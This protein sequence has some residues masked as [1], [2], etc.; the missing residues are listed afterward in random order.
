MVAQ[1]TSK[2]Y[3]SFFQNIFFVRTIFY[4]PLK[5]LLDYDPKRRPSSQS[6]S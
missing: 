2:K 4:T 6:A 1:H 3:T 5:A